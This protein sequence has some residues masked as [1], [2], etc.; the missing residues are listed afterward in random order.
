MTLQLNIII[1]FF[2]FVESSIE[3]GLLWAGSDDGLIHISRNNGESWENVT[4][5]G[6]NETMISIIDA[7]HHDAGTAYFAATSYK[8]NDFQPMIYKTNN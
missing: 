4:P 2:T 3:P 6:L 1:P 7:S 8:F 5:R